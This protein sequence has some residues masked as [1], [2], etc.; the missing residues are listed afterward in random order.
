MMQTWQPHLSPYSERLHTLNLTMK[1]LALS[2]YAYTPLAPLV[3]LLA[4]FRF[5]KKH[6]LQRMQRQLDRESLLKLMV[7]VNP[8]LHA[9]ADQKI[10]QQ[11][12]QKGPWRIAEIG[13]H[14]A[15]RHGLLAAASGDPVHR[16]TP[17]ECLLPTAEKRQLFP[18]SDYMFL[19]R[20]RTDALFQEQLGAPVRSRRQML[21]DTHPFRY[22]ALAGL[23]PM[24]HGGIDNRKIGM[25][26]LDKINQSLREHPEY[27]TNKDLAARLMRPLLPEADALVQ[28]YFDHK[29]VHQLLHRHAYELTLFTGLFYACKSKGKT[30]VTDMLWLKPLDRPLFYTLHQVGPATPW[31]EMFGVTT[32]W[33]ETAAPAAHY[34]VERYL[35]R[36]QTMPM[37][38]AASESLLDDLRRAGWVKGYAPDPVATA[39]AAG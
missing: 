29:T 4:M 31:N 15:S 11:H 23:L 21:Q 18:P 13:I 38:E 19:H 7:N 5:R 24:V 32:P 16:I 12:P 30:V 3:V 36:K 9:V 1:L 6:V 27:S 25:D 39:K 2:A 10:L 28:R 26:L 22:L 20:D 14:F 37:I 33:V 8:S 17:R 34:Q 35:D